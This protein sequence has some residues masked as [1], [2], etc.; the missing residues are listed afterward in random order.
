VNPIKKAKTISMKRVK[1]GERGFGWA[2][3]S[4]I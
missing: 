2:T 1:R 4:N 3:P